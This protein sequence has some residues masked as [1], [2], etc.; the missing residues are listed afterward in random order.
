MTSEISHK[1]ED[2][3]AWLT[4]IAPLKSATVAGFGTSPDCTGCDHDDF[5]DPGA[6]I[7]I[8]FERPG[9]LCFRFAEPSGNLLPSRRPVREPLKKYQR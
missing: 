9:T 1:A 8:T 6:E 5:V 7:R 4:F 3:F 2:V